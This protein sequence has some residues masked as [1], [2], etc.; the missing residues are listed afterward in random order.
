MDGKSRTAGKRAGK[1][2]GKAGEIE[3]DYKMRGNN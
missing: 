1:R 2:A 3:W